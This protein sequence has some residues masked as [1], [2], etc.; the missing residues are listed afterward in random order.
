MASACLAVGPGGR[1]GL[2]AKSR[3]DLSDDLHRRGSLE[4][5]LGQLLVGRPLPTCNI[6]CLSCWSVGDGNASGKTN[7]FCESVEFHLGGACFQK[8]NVCGP[9]LGLRV[10]SPGTWAQW[11]LPPSSPS[12]GAAATSDTYRCLCPASV[13]GHQRGPNS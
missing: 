7:K 1:E 6:W 5:G 12:P 11:H 9:S 3:H 2:M 13:S 8:V 10:L 4:A